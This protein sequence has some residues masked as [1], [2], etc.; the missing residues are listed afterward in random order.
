MKFYQK[1][2]QKTIYSSTVQPE[3][4]KNQNK[5]GENTMTSLRFLND[6]HYYINT[7]FFQI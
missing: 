6:F 5:H 4:I 7:I 1:S 3:S 2:A